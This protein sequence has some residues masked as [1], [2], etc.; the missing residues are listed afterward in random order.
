MDVQRTLSSANLS[1]LRGVTWEAWHAQKPDISR[2]PKGALLQ[3]CQGSLG[4]IP[5]YL[6][7]CI[8]AGLTKTPF[9]AACAS[10][11]PAG[12]QQE[13]SRSPAGKCRTVLFFSNSYFA[14]I[15]RRWK[16]GAKQS[17]GQ[18]ASLRPPCGQTALH[19]KV[20]QMQKPNIKRQ[21][22]PWMAVA[23]R[24][25]AMTKQLK[26]INR[27]VAF[28]ELNVR[29][30]KPGSPERDGKEVCRQMRIWPI[31]VTL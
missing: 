3:K 10:R 19:H 6:R 7:K 2:W 22:T 18:G 28:D 13:P 29:R 8:G 20:P 23:K 27:R 15:W 26:C 21:W 17:A 31:Q 25:H 14:F 9:Q 1:H 30:M 5:G 16:T 24:G 11:S 12:A 4:G